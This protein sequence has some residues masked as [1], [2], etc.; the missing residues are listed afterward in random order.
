VQ[1]AVA[2]FDPQQAGGVILNEVAMGSDEGY[3][4]YGNYGAY[5]DNGS[6]V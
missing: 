4:G 5:G 1:E 6:D 3:Y 2:L